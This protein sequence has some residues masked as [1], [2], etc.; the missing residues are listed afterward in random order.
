MLANY[1]PGCAD[2]LYT[3]GRFLMLPMEWSAERFTKTASLSMEPDTH[4][5][6]ESEADE[7]IRR[8]IWVV[9]GIFVALIALVPA[10]IGFLLK[11]AAGPFRQDFRVVFPE[12]EPDMSGKLD[13]LKLTTFN[14]AALPPFIVAV[15]KLSNSRERVQA[16]ANHILTD[17]DADVFCFQ[18]LFDEEAI[19]ILM[20]TLKQKYLY[21]VAS[22]GNHTFR[23]NSGLCIASKYPITNPAFTPFRAP[24][25]GHDALATKGI[26][27]GDISLPGGK[28]AAL[29]TTHLQA[30]SRN[31]EVRDL[32]LDELNAICE[33]RSRNGAVPVLLGGD[34]NFS[35]HKDSLREGQL[36]NE[37]NWQTPTVTRFFENNQRVDYGNPGD[38]TAFNMDSP[39]TGWDLSRF[40]EWKIKANQI[41]NWF[42]R[43]VRPCRAE[44]NLEV[45][46]WSDHAGLNL[47]VSF[48]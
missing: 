25:I 18:E 37:P 7:R 23:L 6:L 20:D 13:Q 11:T 48:S 42:V 5:R 32:E 17:E 45:G 31:Q 27:R 43:G 16:L 15:N 24:T 44:R 40:N 34:F 12:T 8:I 47:T 35:P 29:V 19:S 46:K 14:V 9:T 39:L 26:L 30:G 36:V 41:D 21:I 3:A 28:T 4:G 33:S 2:S 1:K 38:G 10:I 22:A